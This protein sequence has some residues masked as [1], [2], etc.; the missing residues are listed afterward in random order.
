MARRRWSS[1]STPRETL[2]TLYAILTDDEAAAAA[3]LGHNSGSRSA[4]DLENSHV[5][6]SSDTTLPLDAWRVDLLTSAVTPEAV[7]SCWGSL[8]EIYVSFSV[9][10]STYNA[11]RISCVAPL[12]LHV[13]A[14]IDGYVLQPAEFEALLALPSS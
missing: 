13:I 7:G 2:R 3:V 6:P 11:D 12:R 8:I 4:S 1:S 10:V 9:W 5:S 14:G